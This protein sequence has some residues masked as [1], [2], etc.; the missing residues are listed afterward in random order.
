MRRKN[1]RIDIERKG[2]KAGDL[3]ERIEGWR[4]KRKE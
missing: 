2:E 1:K 3:D 4:L